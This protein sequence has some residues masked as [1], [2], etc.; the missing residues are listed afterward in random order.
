MKRGGSSSVMGGLTH[1]YTSAG[2]LSKS[3]IQSDNERTTE[4]NVSRVFFCSVCAG[5][6]RLVSY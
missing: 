2:G 3:F 5:A 4:E 6:V 1:L